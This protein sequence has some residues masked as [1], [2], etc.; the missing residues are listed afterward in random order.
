[1]KLCREK[2]IYRNVHNIFYEIKYKNSKFSMLD[3]HLKFLYAWK[4]HQKYIPNIK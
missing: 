4:K 2:V 1:M 3:F